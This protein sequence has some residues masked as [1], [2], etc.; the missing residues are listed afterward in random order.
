MGINRHSLEAVKTVSVEGGSIELRLYRPHCI[1]AAERCPLLLT[2]G[3]PGGSSVG[4]YDALHP[5]ADERP[6]VFYDQLG[7]FS[8]PADL[9]PEQMTLKRFS[10]EPL[11]ILNELRIPYAHVFGHS[12]GGSVMTQFC[13]DHPD[14]VKSLLLS[15]PLLS[16]QR[17][18]KDCNHLINRIQQ[19]L[20][21]SADLE[22]EFER[23]H[24]CRSDQDL[25]S[26]ALRCERQRS[27]N[28]LYQQMW[29]PSEF[30]HQGMLGDLDFFPGFPTLSTPTLL[31]CGEYDTATPKTMEDARSAIGE[32]AQLA[33][34]KNAGHKTYVDRNQAFIDVVS[35]YLKQLD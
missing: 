14:R 2:H 34:L 16:T 30:E 35:Q 13:F 4:L 20:G 21:Q 24:F 15:S 9:L 33:V 29:G 5:L 32:S 28:K 22:G 17:W 25:N 26:D 11:C 1:Q 3:G 10:E 8:S 6:T 19:E 7:S 27:N 23:R 18:I 12:W 31:I